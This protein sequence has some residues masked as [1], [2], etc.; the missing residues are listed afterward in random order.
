M[1]RLVDPIGTPIPRVSFPPYPSPYTPM[2]RCGGLLEQQWHGT[3]L[4]TVETRLAWAHSLTWQGL[5]PLSARSR[6]A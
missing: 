1:G 5:H 2:E 3:P 4:I 6:T